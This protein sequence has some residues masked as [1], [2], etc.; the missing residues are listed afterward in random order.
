M[1]FKNYLNF[2]KGYLQIEV[3][4]FFIERFVNNCAKE[5]I[6]LWRTKR[7][8]QTKIL[9]NIEIQDIKRVRKILRQTKCKVKIKKKKGVPFIIKKYRKRK[10]FLIAFILMILII[11]GLSNFVWN[12]EVIGNT[13][14]TQE[15]ILNQLNAQGLE[16]GTL[17]H[18]INT[19]RIIEQMRLANEK[20]AWIGI[21]VEGTNAKVTIVEATEKPEILDKN[22]YCNIISDKEAI[23]TKVNVTNG[24]A[25]VK[26]GDVV[27]KGNLLIAGWIEGQYTG[28]RYMHATGTIKAKVWYTSEKYENYIQDEKVQTEN[29]ENK[30]AICL[31]KN[32]INFFKRVSKFEKYDKIE[33]SKKVKLFNN[34]YLPIEFKKITNYEYKIEKKQY[35]KETLENK[36]TTELEEQMKTDLKDKEILNRDV[37][38]EEKENGIKVRLIYE[39]TEEIG[40]EEKLV[41]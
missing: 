26:E 3:E 37:L 34:F 6:N 31:N 38:V 5:N 17:K 41:S 8:S 32:E 14:I 22:E 25:M 24:T 40:V 35:D 19:N 13:S 11:I 36:I 1:N 7:V 12:I 10:V 2:A 15:E 16:I 33:S 18:K 21:E 9:A 4:G 30:Y 27:E 29:K 20:I 39:V 23:I 28:M